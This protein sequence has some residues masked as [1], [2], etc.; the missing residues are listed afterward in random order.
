MSPTIC[1]KKQHQAHVLQIWK[2]CSRSKAN[3]V[4][5]V[6]DQKQRSREVIRHSATEPLSCSPLVLQPNKWKYTLFLKLAALTVLKYKSDHAIFFRLKPEQAKCYVSYCDH[7]E[8]MP[9]AP[10]KACMINTNNI[11]VST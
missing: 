10:L 7:K 2:P 1:I 8:I 3:N 9:L 6:M 4:T 11:S 5:L